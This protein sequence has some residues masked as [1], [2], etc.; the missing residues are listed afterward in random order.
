MLQQK[1]EK[2]QKRVSNT[3]VNPVMGIADG[4]D[5]VTDKV[6]GNQRAIERLCQWKDLN[7]RVC[8]TGRG[9]GE[10]TALKGD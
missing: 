7:N 5:K 1:S 4:N 3:A 9:G 10:Q 6:L 8:G 2:L